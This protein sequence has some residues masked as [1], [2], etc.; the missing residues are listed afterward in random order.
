MN[1]N[2]ETTKEEDLTNSYEQEIE[3]FLHNEY[4]LFKDNRFLKELILSDINK[5]H[6]NLLEKVYFFRKRFTEHNEEL[7]EAI[8]NSLLFNST[9]KLNKRQ[10]IF[11]SIFFSIP[12]FIVINTILLITLLLK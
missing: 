5:S 2:K 3:N 6:E 11:Y 4:E 8:S 10:K 12:L 9:I 1:N 7:D